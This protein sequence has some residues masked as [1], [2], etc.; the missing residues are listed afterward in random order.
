MN[1]EELIQWL[2][3]V[4]VMIG[5]KNDQGEDEGKCLLNAL[6]NILKNEK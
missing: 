2:I 6:I 4:Y 3:D 1:R 5:E